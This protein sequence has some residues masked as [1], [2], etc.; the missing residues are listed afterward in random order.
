VT[1]DEAD[2]AIVA[3]L[4]GAEEAF[5]GGLGRGPLVHQ[6]E[7]FRTERRVRPRLGGDGADPGP[8]PRDDGPDAGEPGCDGD[9]QIARRRVRG[10][11][12]ERHPAALTPCPG[13]AAGR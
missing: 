12:R 10:H 2:L 5:E 13:G 7:A 1:I 4:V 9:A 6:R 3:A 11:D 8:R